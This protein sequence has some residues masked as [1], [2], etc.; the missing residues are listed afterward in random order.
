MRRPGC[1]MALLIALAGCGGGGGVGRLTV[2]SPA[3][4]PGGRIPGLYTCDGR[5]ISPPLRW[6]GVP[7]DATQL[8]LSMTDPDAPGGTFIHWQVSMISP[9]ASAVQ[10]GRVPAVATE[11]TNSFGTTGYR[12]PCPPRGSRP[13]RYV[14]TVTALN[15]GQA[16]ASGSLT[17]IYSRG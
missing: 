15:G 5:D 1:E 14:I 7:S 2:S 17:G 9:G 16:L 11:G 6:S 4:G 10:A 12:G 13:H 8:T 3:F